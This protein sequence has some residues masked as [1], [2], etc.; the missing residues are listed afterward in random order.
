MYSVVFASK[1]SLGQTM[2]NRLLFDLN[3]ARLNSVLIP[4]ND[5]VDGI[6]LKPEIASIPDGFIIVSFRQGVDNSEFMHS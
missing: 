6:R 2:I 1:N 3:S 4:L 5:F